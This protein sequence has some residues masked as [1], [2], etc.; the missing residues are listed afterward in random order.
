MQIKRFQCEEGFL[1][2]LDVSFV[3]G[4][5]VIIG[6]R[7]AGKTSIVE[8]VRFC[9]G[10]SAYSKQAASAAREHALSVLGSGRVTLTLDVDGE[11]V[12][13]TRTAV[14]DSA[15]RSRD[16]VLVSPVVLS[17][18]EI[19]QV[20]LQAAGRLRLV[21]GF[22][23][24]AR[25]STGRET[26]VRAAIGSVTVE[27]A[28]LAA[29]VRDLEDSVAKVLALQADL[30]VALAEQAT[31]DASLAELKA[32]RERLG[33][34]DVGLTRSEGVQEIL[35]RSLRSVGRWIDS[36]G[37][38]AMSV[39]V[40]PQWPDAAGP[41][42]IGAVRQSVDR[43]ASL[44]RE[45]RVAAEEA[46]TELMRLEAANRES[47]LGWQDESRDL[48]RLLEAAAE[49]AGTAA[50]KVSQVQAQ[51]GRAPALR[52][53]V[54]ARKGELAELQQQ[55]AAL[56][57][58]LDQLRNARIAERQSVVAS[59]NEAFGPQ[60]HFEVQPFASHGDYASAIAAGLQG[61]GLH[62]NTLAPELAA[63]LSPRELAELTENYDL[64]G[65]M[66]LTGLARDRAGRVLAAL[67]AGGLENILSANV[68][69]A[70]ELSLLDGTGYK[71]STRLSTGQRCT[72]VLPIL[73]RHQDRVL[74]MDQPEDHLDNAFVVDTVVKAMRD[75]GSN[76]QLIC[77]TH[78]P[79]VPVLGGAMK[80]ILLGSDGRRGFVREQGDLDDPSI[81]EAITNV[82]EG[83]KEAFRRRAQFYG[84]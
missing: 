6:P 55:R 75:R 56:L 57:D 21:D 31:F 79:N 63:A 66:E 15:R 53:A 22:R 71:P 72:I 10:P 64:E 77:T 70:V 5:N 83:G 69:D 16:L 40:V 76:A 19:E 3:P 11:E 59:L 29:E 39:P 52:A 14:D 23:P 60:L 74:V 2:D 4:L 65:L 32:E 24:P 28:A 62:Y 7:G 80:V 47:M 38:A 18:N 49:G 67:A 51:L 78:N 34:I 46:L 26:E 37:P 43:A 17:Q 30:D 82:M 48:R 20:G 44:L 45:A 25:Q 58:E 27:I 36:F 42:A 1:D 13:V 73:L 50:R 61:T 68:D 33:Q 81:V 9:L 54:V 41:D 84:L 12:L 35:E 8:L